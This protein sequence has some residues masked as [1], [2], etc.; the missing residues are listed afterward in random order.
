MSVINV[1]IKYIFDSDFRFL[2]NSNKNPSA[3]AKMD[4]K[5]YLSKRYHALFGKTIDWNRP[6][7]FNEKL[8]W[9]KINDRN[10][11]YP[12]LVD[13]YEVKK[14]IAEKLGEQYIIR[15]LGVW[16]SVD[17]IDFSELPKQFVLKTTHDSKG[18]V[19]CKN[20]DEIDIKAIRDRLQ[21][22]L[23][24]NFFLPGREWPYKLVKPR[25][26]AEEYMI[27]DNDNGLVDY[28]FHCF[29]GEP[30]LV[31]VCENR[32]GDSGL[33]ETFYDMDWNMLQFGRP[34]QRRRTKA[35]DVPAC[36]KEMIEISKLLSEN[37]PFVRVDL[38]QIKNQVYFGELT[39]YPA[40]GFKHF[41][42]DEIDEMLG[43]WLYLPNEL[44]RS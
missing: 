17:E 3:F 21:K 30:K 14:I 39:F 22:C 38:Y 16:D 8:Q 7:T 42:P 28:K 23:I 31:L 26:I 36:F 41:E 25:I 11:N 1:I 19:I 9:L 43:D 12:L 34:G 2:L 13:K 10:D 15:N 24:S 40:S 37:I 5:T 32:F 44:N 18:V 6:K 35:G 20:K 4:D 33:I 27:D 29:N